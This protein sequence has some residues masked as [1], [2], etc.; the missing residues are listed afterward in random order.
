MNSKLQ[1]LFTAAR[2]F[3]RCNACG[4]HVSFAD[5]MHH[6][7]NEC[8]ARRAHDRGPMFGITQRFVLR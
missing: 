6:A 5:A 8:N 2:K 3:Y 4:V 7:R 1:S